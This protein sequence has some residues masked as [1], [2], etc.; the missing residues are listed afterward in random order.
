V[1]AAEDYINTPV[2]KTVEH[3]A[4]NTKA[5]GLISRESMN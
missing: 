1:N 4:G 3:W 2:A 5:I